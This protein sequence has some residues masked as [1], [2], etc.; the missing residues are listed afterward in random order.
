MMLVCFFGTFIGLGFACLS[1]SVPIMVFNATC[2]ICT[3]V[4]WSGM[5]H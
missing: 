2:M 4:L 3:A 1:G 5:D